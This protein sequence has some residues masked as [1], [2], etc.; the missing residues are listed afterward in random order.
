MLQMFPELFTKSRVRPVSDYPRDLR[1]SLVGVR[2][3]RHR[4][5][6]RGR[7]AHP[8]HPQLRLLRARV[9][10]RPDGGRTG[11]GPRP[12]GRRRTHRDAH[13][14]GSGAD[15]RALSPSRRR[16]SRPADLPAR[17][18]ARR[19][20]GHGRLP[21]RVGS[22]S[23]THRAPGIADDKAIYS[24]MP[25][26]IDFYTGEKPLLQNVP[27]V[28]L[29]R[30]RVARLRARPPRRA[31]R[32][33]GPRV[34][35]LR[36]ARRPGGEQAGDREVP[37]Q[38]RRTIRRTTSPSRPWRCRRCRSSPAAASRPAMS[39]CARSSSSRPNEIRITPG[40]L[41]RVAMKRG[42]LVVNSSQGGGTKDTWV[43][44]D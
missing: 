31:G 15:R 27:D 9:P 11:R 21:A 34:G 5:P 39:T 1:A 13:H 17:F 37:A 6:P 33:G 10:G 19:S 30:G 2:P 40:G 41:T 7:R 43:M 18:P 8:G 3:R 42:S 32:Q 14:R 12:V 28:A 22:P 23:P 29:L 36:D 26:I 35:R 24:Y 44:E 20:R 16:L 38:A 25:E 4:G